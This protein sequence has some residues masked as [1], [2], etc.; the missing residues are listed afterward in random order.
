M[1]IAILILLTLLLLG[2]RIP[3]NIRQASSNPPQSSN[4]Q[5]TS[6]NPSSSNLQTPHQ[7]RTGSSYYPAR[8]KYLIKAQKV[9]L[10]RHKKQTNRLSSIK[11][12]T[13]QRQLRIPSMLKKENKSII[14][15]FWGDT[16]F[17]KFP[18]SLR[19]CSF[20]IHNLCN[21]SE[22]PTLISVAQHYEIDVLGLQELGLDVNQGKVRKDIHDAT[23]HLDLHQVNTYST[24]PH[25]GDDS[26]VKKYGGTLMHLS[27][28]WSTRLAPV[29]KIKPKASDKTRQAIKVPN[30]ST[31]PSHKDSSRKG[32]EQKSVPPTTTK[33]NTLDY[34][35]NTIF[36]GHGAD[37]MG[38]WSSFTLQG[39][40]KKR[41]TI[42]SAYCVCRSSLKDAGSGTVWMQEYLCH[43]QTGKCDPDPRQLFLDDLSQFIKKLKVKITV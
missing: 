8:S 14:N 38:R 28:K 7:K 9:G 18:T 17:S 32:I 19:L 3:N 2:D 27:G 13:H 33:K 31:Q 15:D 24:S 16:P 11:Q 34:V 21:V 1:Q 23:Q 41:L 25:G 10:H 39:K 4:Y 40:T 43:L 29:E 42:I 22:L 20:D 5:T 35:G 30:A 12:K 26:S 36:S 6:S 37:A